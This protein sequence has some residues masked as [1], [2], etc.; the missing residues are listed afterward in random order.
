[1]PVKRRRMRSLGEGKVERGDVR[2]GI[3]RKKRLSIRDGMRRLKS[4]RGASTQKSTRSH[5]RNA[6][7]AVVADTRLRIKGLQIC[8][9]FSASHLQLLKRKYRKQGRRSASKTTLI[10]SV[11][12]SFLPKRSTRLSRGRSLLVRPRTSSVTL[13]QGSSMMASSRAGGQSTEWPMSESGHLE[14]VRTINVRKNPHPRPELTK[15]QRTNEDL[16][17]MSG[18][19]H[20]TGQQAV[21]RILRIGCPISKIGWT[22]EAHIKMIRNSGPVLAHVP[23][24]HLPWARQMQVI[25]L[26]DRQPLIQELRRRR[27]RLERT[28]IIEHL[29][30]LSNQP[31]VT[32]E[33]SPDMATFGIIRPT[34]NQIPCQASTLSM[35]SQRS[36]VRSR[37]KPYVAITSFMFSSRTAHLKVALR[38]IGK[39]CQILRSK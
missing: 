26:Q 7:L 27:A 12:R 5:E 35:E 29:D 10:G 11:A 8:M 39:S 17:I 3:G 36:V 19:G 21:I 22:E 23:N 13:R 1:M 6:P 18:H 28:T 2:S 30:R 38:D 4:I 14:G 32:T 34:M 15:L 24:P 37:L 33:P 20:M 25:N 9:L 31:T 16:A